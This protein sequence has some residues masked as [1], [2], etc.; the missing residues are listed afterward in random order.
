M[1]LIER[2]QEENEILRE[3]VAHLQSALAPPEMIFPDLC[4]QRGEREVLAL[5]VRRPVVSYDN[6]QSFRYGAGKDV[7]NDYRL[8]T[9]YVSHLR[10][11][12][13]LLKIEIHVSRGVGYY[14]KKPCRDRL[15]GMAI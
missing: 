5:L 15:R 2:L 13:R 9:V 7:G 12:L 4:L 10:K 11:K 8:L 6:Y 3:Q 14:I 1:S